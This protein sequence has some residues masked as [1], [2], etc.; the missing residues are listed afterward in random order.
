MAAACII[1]K[2][3]ILVTLPQLCVAVV[4]YYNYCLLL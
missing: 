4:T 1:I 3:N 2:F